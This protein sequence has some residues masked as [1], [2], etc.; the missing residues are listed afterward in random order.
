MV[1]QA[2][3]VGWTQRDE[4]GISKWIL[5]WVRT[6]ESKKR[7]RRAQVGH[8]DSTHLHRRFSNL[9]QRLV[10][11]HQKSI[12]VLILSLVDGGGLCADAAKIFE[13]ICVNH[14]RRRSLFLKKN[15]ESGDTK[16]IRQTVFFLFSAVVS[17]R[18]LLPEAKSSQ[19]LEYVLFFFAT[20]PNLWFV[21][22]GRFDDFGEACTKLFGSNYVQIGK[23]DKR[24]IVQSE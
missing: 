7:V 5:R 19:P 4:D 13:A 11:Q 8:E 14:R 1:D 20:L 17:T 22:V 12:L 16:S 9:G 10:S 24:C 15:E 18:L 23:V 21:V 3:S 6:P 2:G